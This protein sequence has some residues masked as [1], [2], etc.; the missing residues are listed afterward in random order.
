MQKVIILVIILLSLT[1]TP[2]LAQ[3]K[4]NAFFTLNR[5]LWSQSGVTEAIGFYR[6]KAYIC[7]GTACASMPNSAYIDLIFCSL[8]VIQ[9]QGF[10]MNGLLF[11]LIGIGS[12][13]NSNADARYDMFKI[14]DFWT[15]L[16]TITED[17]S[18]QK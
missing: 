10:K 4:P 12:A 3:L 1:T 15:P 8:F 16:F 6:N 13:A 2:C 17:N 7:L 5:T 18:E 14:S 11:P 9:T